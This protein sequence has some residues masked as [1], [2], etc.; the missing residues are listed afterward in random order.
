MNLGQLAIVLSPSPW[1]YLLLHADEL[2]FTLSLVEPVYLCA[3]LLSSGFGYFGEACVS[4]PM[5]S[6]GLSTWK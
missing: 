6:G 4:L 2:I 1:V 3:F 5:I